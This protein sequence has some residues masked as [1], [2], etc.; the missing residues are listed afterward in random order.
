MGKRVLITG[1]AGNL[2]GLLAR[3]LL[4]DEV[5]LHL[6]VHRQDVSPELKAGRILPFGRVWEVLWTGLIRSFI[7]PGSFSS[8]IR[9]S[10]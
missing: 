5:L 2:G 7:L 10:F 6:L 9:K 8:I 1:A 4:K 3:R